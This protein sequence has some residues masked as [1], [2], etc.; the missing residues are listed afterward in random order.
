MGKELHVG[1]S[2]L[3][4]RSP[5]VVGDIQLDTEGRARE[6]SEADECTRHSDSKQ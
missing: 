1:D 4:R 3:H 6:M 2:M 5:S